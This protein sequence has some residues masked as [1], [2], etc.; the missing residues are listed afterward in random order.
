MPTGDDVLW[1]REPSSTQTTAL[2]AAIQQTQRLELS[3]QLIQRIVRMLAFIATGHD[4]CTGMS[5]E[6]TPA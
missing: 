4:N 5:F 1:H 3:Q 6:A 2:S